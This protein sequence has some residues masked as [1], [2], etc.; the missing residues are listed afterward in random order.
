M[1]KR[2]IDKGFTV[3]GGRRAGCVFPVAER[4]AVRRFDARVLAHTKVIGGGETASV[5][6]KPSLLKPGKAHVFFC[7]FPGHSTIMHGTVTLTKSQTASVRMGPG[8]NV[9]HLAGHR[10]WQ[11]APRAHHPG[12][13]NTFLR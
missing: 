3:H 12:V 9:V 10:P 6:F 4:W 2:T 11:V 1:Q 13:A 8:R 7:S 5:T